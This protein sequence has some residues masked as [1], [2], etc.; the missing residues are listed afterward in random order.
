M[1]SAS[2]SSIDTRA[3]S[4]SAKAS[5]IAVIG[6]SHM[7][8]LFNA[9][10]ENPGAHPPY[11]FLNTSPFEPISE[12]VQIAEL[13]AQFRRQFL[14]VT[15]DALLVGLVI[16]G[17]QHISQ[18]LF[19]RSPAIEVILSDFTDL[20]Y[21]PDAQLVPERLFDEIFD[22]TQADL[23]SM[24]SFCQAELPRVKLVVFGPPPPIVDAAV[25]V[26]QLDPSLRAQ[27]I[28][29][30]TQPQSADISPALLRWKIWQLLNR[31]FER[32]AKK[33]D[34]TWLPVPLE[35]FDASGKFLAKALWGTDA[36]HANSAYG[37]LRLRQ[38]EKL[39]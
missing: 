18:S 31:S 11:R 36:T 9:F 22:R 14:A 12:T 15:A 25:I 7:V 4:A 26:R 30:G 23:F 13:S 2:P 20:W 28:E 29:G 16:N 8:A 34:A 3:D 39:L 5:P 37:Q 35:A 6:R 32:V 17:N 24:L 27:F 21:A 33:F 1:Q 10:R 19:S 38:L